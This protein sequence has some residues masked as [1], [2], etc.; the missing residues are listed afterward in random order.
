V[1]YA[2]DCLPP[3]TCSAQMES[4]RRRLQN[5][6]P[7]VLLIRYIS[8][9]NT[10]LCS[11]WLLLLV[12]RSLLWLAPFCGNILAAAGQLF[13]GVHCQRLYY[14]NRAYVAN[15]KALRR[16]TYRAQVIPR[17]AIL[18]NIPLLDV[19]PCSG[20]LRP[21]IPSPSQRHRS[22]SQRR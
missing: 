8:S 21:W 11:L 20:R 22:D 2:D 13:S 17:T 16:M 12:A 4:H 6:T 14:R 15:S 18:Q 7:H 5:P 3:D 9:A 19:S 1:I 10:W